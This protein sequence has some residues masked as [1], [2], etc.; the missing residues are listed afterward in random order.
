MPPTQAG[1]EVTAVPGLEEPG[2]HA[3]A[4]RA[5]DSA[6]VQEFLQLLA[7][8]VHQFRAYPPASPLC[9]DAIAACHRV[10]SSFGGSDQQLVV[11][12]APR[13]LLLGDTGFGAGTVVEHELARRLHR[14]SVAGLAIDTAASPRDLSW[15]C[16]DLLAAER[17]CAD[18]ASLAELLIEHGVDT[19]EPQMAPQP[20]IVNVG[21]PPAPLCAL[22]ESE[23][24]RRKSA[25]PAAPAAHLYPPDRG[26]VRMDPA[27]AFDA[28][29]LS[30]L[31]ILL[32]DPHRLARVLLGLTDDGDGV[33][34]GS[35]DSAL[36]RKF[37]DVARILSS[38]EPSLARRMFQKLARAV[39][40]M[41][42]A[43][44]QAL[45]RRTILPGLLDQRA[46]GAVLADFP[47]VDLAQAL[48]LLL[49]L[50]TAA[51]E[52]LTTALDRMSL[53]EERRRAVAP[54]LDAEIRSRSGAIVRS[55]GGTGSAA[56]TTTH[57]YA[58]R[59]VRVDA[60]SGR[61]FH[62]FASFDLAVDENASKAID[63]VRRQVV[64]TDPLAAQLSC[65]LALVRLEPN[66][67]AVSRLLGRAMLLLGEMAAAG[68]WSEMAA[69]LRTQREIVE[70]LAHKRPDVAEAIES[71][72]ARFCTRQRAIKL[73]DLW[74]A[75]GDEHAAADSFVRA[76]GGALAPALVAILADTD[77]QARWP[78]LVRMMSEHA[79][80]FAPVLAAG[81]V[82]LDA[83]TARSVIRVLGFAGPGYEAPVI[84]HLERHPGDEATA[85][86]GLG[87]LSR[88]GTLRA[89]AAIA[90]KLR[91]GDSTT[92]A[93]AEEALWRLPA[94][95]A[96]EQ[97]R[98]L[99]KRKDFVLRN[100]KTALHLLERAA[101]AG[102]ANLAP[103]AA[104]LAPLRFHF[105]NPAQA[106]VGVRAR[107]IAREQS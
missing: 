13:E 10:L 95:H 93:A 36:E 81:L 30:D 35:V 46:E 92:R 48:C 86:V 23:R 65:L 77:L 14:A 75:G 22:V 69:W 5:P 8:A 1:S 103:A 7:R 32:D 71:S 31:A 42:P 89:A 58:R 85:R 25:E 97:V 41:E 39:L 107:E 82:N 9:Q 15:F 76:C 3:P 84:A 27:S 61:K 102:A 60:A 104:A 72:L 40:D 79:K 78:S 49:D 64:E 37:S 83:A 80:L 19:I 87:A 47:D 62:E 100:P 4:F 57:S 68:R 53:P 63:G 33:V 90:A 74:D 28:V 12:V 56:D 38:V 106:R 34:Q 17:K 105:W 20:E 51:P 55:E 18:R 6:A 43:R 70:G 59:L 67:D 99:L 24:K 16:R 96:H 11:R 101:Q 21:M 45:L 2:A 44:R 52:V 26:W 73:I 66:P 98:E 94:S 88:I 91:D 29:S 50:E 54:L